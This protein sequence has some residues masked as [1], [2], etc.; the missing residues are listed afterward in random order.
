MAKR[1]K[2]GVRDVMSLYKKGAGFWLPRQRV[3]RHVPHIGGYVVKD[4][5]ICY[6]VSSRYGGT[7][8]R[9][10]PATKQA[11]ER[12]REIR[13]LIKKHGDDCRYWPEWCLK[14][15]GKNTTKRK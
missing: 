5:E 14:K 2:I 3:E 15:Y 11:I 7:V 4:G 9:C 1:K 10:A 6:V 13:R 8:Y 12:A